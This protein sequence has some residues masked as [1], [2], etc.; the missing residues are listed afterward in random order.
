[1]DDTTDNDPWA[2]ARVIKVCSKCGRHLPAPALSP[3]YCPK[4]ELVNALLVERYTTHV[5]ETDNG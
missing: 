3:A 1:M 2:D 5:R 4:C